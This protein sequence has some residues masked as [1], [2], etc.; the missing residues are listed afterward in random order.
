MY[1]T[2]TQYEY[3]LSLQ[4]WRNNQIIIIIIL[5][6][7]LLTYCYI[8]NHM[9]FHEMQFRSGEAPFYDPK[10]ARRRHPKRRKIRPRRPQD[11]FQDPLFSFWFLSS[12]LVRLGCHFCL[13]FGPPLGAQLVRSDGTKITRNDP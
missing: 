1:S 8:F 7:G 3:S 9:M 5:I 12:V 10:T 2:H 4:L 11:D 13:F 6:I